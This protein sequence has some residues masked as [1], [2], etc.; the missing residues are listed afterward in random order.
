MTRANTSR[1]YV[2]LESNYQQALDYSLK[3]L[4][5]RADPESMGARLD[6]CA[7]CYFAVGNIEKAIVTQKRAIKL[8]PHSPPLQR[9]LK[10]FLGAKEIQDHP[11]STRD[12]PD[13]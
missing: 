5:F 7:R 11:E 10:E 8:M 1:C 13:E 4:E 3:S 12:T 6:T 9:Q 2:L